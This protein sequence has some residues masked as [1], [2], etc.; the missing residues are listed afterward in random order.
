MSLGTIKQ[1]IPSTI[2]FPSKQ[3]LILTLCIPIP[4]ID[5]I[6]TTA[7]KTTSPVL[8]LKNKDYRMSSE[9][10]ANGARS[11]VPRPNIIDVYNISVDLL[12]FLSSKGFHISLLAISTISCQ[13]SCL[14][15]LFIDIK[16]LSSRKNEADSRNV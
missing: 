16:K 4:N 8:K 9:P 13:L 3:S 6:C 1:Y 10:I 14:Y 2:I 15:Y 11:W 7:S 5:R 12:T